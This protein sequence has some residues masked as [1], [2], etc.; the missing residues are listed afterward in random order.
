M[1]E[2]QAP[3]TQMITVPEMEWRALVTRIDALC[4]ILR[5]LLDGFIASPMAGM[6]IDVNTID[7]LR[8]AL[9]A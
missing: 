3:T 1:S 7:M 5:M 4:A 8:D 6:L 2:F 9:S